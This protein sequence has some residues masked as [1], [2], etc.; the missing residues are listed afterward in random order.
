MTTK[1]RPLKTAELKAEFDRLAAQW[2]EET[3]YHSSSTIIEEHPAY[4]AIIAMGENVIP[5]IL[6][7][8]RAS[9]GHWFMALR[10]I[11]GESP[12]RE[13]D[14]GKIQAIR[15]AWLEWGVREGYIRPSA[16]KG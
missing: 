2:R 14:R 1:R 16:D 10:S 5:L 6:E 13:E 8:L 9:G 4:Q 3:R 7:N 15:A 11:T 12:I